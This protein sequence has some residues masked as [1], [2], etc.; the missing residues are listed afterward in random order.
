MFSVSPEHAIGLV[1]GILSIPIALL[2]LRRQRAWREAA[3]T[4]KGA[5]VLMVFTAVVHLALIGHHLESEPVTSALFLVNGALF[6][7]LAFSTGWQRW[8]VASSL[9]LVATILGYL[10]YVVADLEGPDQV[11]LA[12]KLVELTALGLVLVPVRGEKRPSFRRTRWAALGVAMPV[13][14]ITTSASL[15]IVDLVRPDPRHVHAG[16][17][18]QATNPVATQEQWDA[19]NALYRE[20]KLAIA[21]YVDWRKAWAAGYRPGGP[22]NMP[23]THWMNQRYVDAGYVMDPQHPQGLVY[24]NSTHGPVLLG[25]M[26]QMKRIGQFGPDPGGPVTAWHQHENICFAPLGFEFSLL[27]P[28]ATCPLGA[29]NISAPPMLHV[30]IV[31]NPAGPFAVDIDPKVVTQIDR[32]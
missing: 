1:A 2:V 5:A 14:L 8:R 10:I 11:G 25:A 18:L 32:S 19:A 30:W 4:V 17:L 31:N 9:L 26:F 29:I 3:G 7:V 22:D 12:T 27:T 20:T 15:W 16:A 13:L 21:P 6:F 23:S 24:A 28:T